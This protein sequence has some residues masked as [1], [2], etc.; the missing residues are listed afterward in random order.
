MSII[1]MR[2]AAMLLMLVFCYV[3]LV[4]FSNRLYVPPASKKVK[5]RGN[6]R[7]DRFEAG[8]LSIAT[9]NIGYAG[10][11]AES[12]SVWDMGTQHKPT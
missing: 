2:V 8:T 4:A 5:F 1:A 6:A 9:W 7:H 12:D 10:L 3:G 11:G